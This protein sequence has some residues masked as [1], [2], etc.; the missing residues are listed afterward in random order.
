MNREQRLFDALKRISQY[1]GPERLRRCSEQ[2]YGLSYEE[3]LEMAYDNVLME[4]KNA[5]R[6]MR[7][8]A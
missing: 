7:R 2:S 8:P 6:G 3:S 4:A 5:I 1:E